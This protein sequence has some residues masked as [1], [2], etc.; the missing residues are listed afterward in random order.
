MPESSR[1]EKPPS[2]SPTNDP[3]ETTGISAGESQSSPENQSE[4]FD[5]SKM[6]KTKPGI[7]R[8]S[9][10][11][12]VLFSF[13]LGFPF[14]LK[15]VEI[16]RSPLPFKY[17][18][19]LSSVIESEPLLFPCQFQAVFLGFRDELNDADKLGISIVERMREVVGND[20][21]CGSCRSNF[22]V[23]I[24]LE[25]EKGCVQ[26][27]NGKIGCSWQCELL[28]DN[29]F[30]AKWKDD[31]Y[32]DGL[33]ENA[34]SG[35][36]KCAGSKGKVYS[37]VVVKNDEEVRAVAGKHRHGWIIG[38]VSEAEAVERIAEIFVRVFMNGGKDEG[39]I[40]GEFMPVGADGRVVL[41]FSLL[42]SNP[43]DWIYD[44][45]FQRVNEIQLTPIVEALAPIANISVESQILYHTPKSFSSYWDYQRD[46][47]IYDSK[48]LPF[49]M[50][51]GVIVWNPSGCS[52][53]S[54]TL[55]EAR[56]TISFKD[57]ENIVDVFMGQLR[58]L[59]GLKSE[60]LYAGSSGIVNL[61]ASERGFTEWEL[62]LLARQHTCFNLQSCATTLGSLS[63]LVQSLPRMIIKDEI[64]KQVQYS[65]HAANFAR[66]N[67]TLGAY[68]DS[69]VLSRQARSLAEDA[70]FHPSI[71]SVSYYSFEHCFAVYSPFFLPVA[72]H[73]LLAAFKEWKR[74]KQEKL[75]YLT[76]KA[77]EVAS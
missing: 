21:A 11:L 57:L 34:V 76:W 68:D 23:S 30:D 17:M 3:G 75:K 9:L 7:K 33:L 66:S 15:S 22:T 45:D 13:I 46:A 65:L 55:R 59:F 70:F 26:S 50:W 6:R 74:Y 5:S 8:L 60:S 54:E 27:N 43:H 32:V 38:K 56:H 35:S 14:L 58:Q 4:S 49:F 2:G 73:V 25:T 77:K 71:M 12:S 72:L 48:D 51:G 31:E 28:K 41:S 42:N 20:Q 69:A 39:S 19:S 40:H 18:D 16:Y 64:G 24:S 53:H 36:Q 63:R 62:D 67:A 29:D 44:W 1:R 10:T 52:G 47:Y 61:L 37:V